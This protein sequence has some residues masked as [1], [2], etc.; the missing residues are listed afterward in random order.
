[1][2]G[3]LGAICQKQK[4]FQIFSTKKLSLPLGF[5]LASSQIISCLFTFKLFIKKRQYAPTSLIALPIGREKEKNNKMFM[6][7]L[8]R[9]HYQLLI[10]NFRFSLEMKLRG[11]QTKNYRSEFSMLN[12]D[13]SYLFSKVSQN[14]GKYH[15]LKLKP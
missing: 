3:F 12:P 4:I 8:R 15:D 5:W 1:M 14:F 13:V 10:F 2:A 9:A 7:L 11:S 6:K